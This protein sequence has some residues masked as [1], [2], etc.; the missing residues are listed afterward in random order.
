M[1]G[2][3]YSQMRLASMTELRVTPRLVMDEETGALE[4]PEYLPGFQDGQCRT[5]LRCDRDSQLFGVGLAL[6]RNRLAGFL[7]AFEV[8]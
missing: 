8:A 2:Q 4:S 5:H 7:Q 6:V 1:P 3:R